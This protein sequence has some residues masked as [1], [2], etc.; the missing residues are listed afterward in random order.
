MKTAHLEIVGMSCGHCVNAVEGA[1]RNTPG[2]RAASVSIGAADVEYDE[3][4]VSP[5]QLADAVSQEG[6]E[7]TTVA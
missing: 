5:Q 1:L 4:S 7:V 3:S 2:V 6:Y